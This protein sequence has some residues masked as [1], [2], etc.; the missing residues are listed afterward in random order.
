MRQI[1]SGAV[2]AGALVAALYFL[3]FWRRSHDRLF[4]F[5]A[6]AFL[7]M[8]VNGVALGLTDP[9]SEVRV[10][11]YSVRLAAFVLILLAILDKNRAL[12]R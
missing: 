4:A 9:K 10:Y 11:L 8:S 3:K 2:A 5:F 6:A 12:R 7:L 1:L